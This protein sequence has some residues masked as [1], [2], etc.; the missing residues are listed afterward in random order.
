[1][2]RIQRKKEKTEEERKRILGLKR[3]EKEDYG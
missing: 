2:K 3:I 1:L